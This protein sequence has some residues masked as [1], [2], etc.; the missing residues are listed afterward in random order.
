VSEVSPSSEWAHRVDFS[1][2][3]TSFSD[4]ESSPSLS[5]L[6]PLI[7][8]SSTLSWTPLPPLPLVIV[9]TLALFSLEAI[10]LSVMKSVGITVYIESPT[11]ILRGAR[12]CSVKR[13]DTSSPN[14]HNND[15]H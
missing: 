2:E 14:G 4:K 8:A 6:S 1:S 10:V 5:S 7:L 13:H 11:P 15:K 9:D 3:E 12:D